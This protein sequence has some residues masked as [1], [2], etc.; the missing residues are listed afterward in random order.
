MYERNGKLIQ[1]VFKKYFLPTIM[2][3]MALSMGIIVDGIIVGNTLGPDALA[4]VNIVLPVTLCFSAIYA[5]FG[6]GGSVLASIAKGTRDNRRADVIFT[7]S[8]LLMLAVSLIFLL[9]GSVFSKQLVRLLAGN[10][11][12]E[13]LVAEYMGILIYGAPLLIV[14]PGIVYFVRADGRPNMAS[15]VLI[16]ANVVNLCLDMVFILWFKMG[17]GGAALATVVGYAVG[18]LILL[19]YFFSNGRS[20]SFT[21]FG[22]KELK[23]VSKIVVCGIPSAVGSSL[24]FVKILSINAIVLSRLGPSGMVVFS[25]CLSCLSFVSMFIAG[26]AQTMMPIVATLYGEKDYAGVRFTIRRTLKVIMLAS[27][28]LVIV[29][30]LF[31][32]AVLYLFGV[33]DAAEFKL[34]SQAIRIFALSLIGTGFSFLM[35]YYFQTIQRSILATVITIVQGVLVVVPVAFI[36]SAFWGAIGIWIAF[37]LAEICTF[38]MIFGVTKVIAKNSEGRFEGL[39][40]LTRSDEEDCILDVTIENRKSEAVG[41]SEKVIQFCLSHK[42]DAKTARHVGLA[43]EEMAV[44]TIE[45]GYMRNDK[46]YIDIIIR[47]KEEEVI[48]SLR[49]GGIPFN[50]TLYKEEEEKTYSLSGILLV[51]A[52]AKSV[53][54]ARLIGLNST[55]ISLIA[56]KIR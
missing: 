13:P 10:S 12:L 14:I 49:D 41:L 51:K 37:L 23:V 52:L 4:A 35:L 16:T 30:E 25:V 54:Y 5:L 45:H 20:F 8:V 56:T 15:V 24:L 18:F 34:G 55:I 46:N 6:V 42:I 22:K 28:T 43:V 53:N 44:N 9:A 1:N 17:I 33:R 50:P 27:I 7:L 36:L 21:P 2:M 48:I 11:S 47:V 31:P 19:R 32:V 26:A 38:I 29:F 39:F 3:T 40:L